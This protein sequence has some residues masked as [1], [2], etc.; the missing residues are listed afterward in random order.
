M[1]HWRCAE[2]VHDIEKIENK[3]IRLGVHNGVHIKNDWRHG[4]TATPVIKT[5]QKLYC[6]N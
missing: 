1:A 2:S 6:N 3:A 4:F 5:K